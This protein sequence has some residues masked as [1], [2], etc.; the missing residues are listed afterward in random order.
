[1]TVPFQA[2]NVLKKKASESR[3]AV[4]SRQSSSDGDG[5]NDSLDEGSCAKEADPIKLENLKKRMKKYGDITQNAR[6]TDELE[7]L[8]RRFD[9]RVPAV[10]FFLEERVRAKGTQVGRK[11]MNMFTQKF[12]QPPCRRTS[13][14]HSTIAMGSSTSHPALRCLWAAA[15]RR[16]RETGRTKSESHAWWRRM[17]R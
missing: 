3:L 2:S 15:P 14:P 1:M 4:L 8:L 7:E 16:R 13:R 9:N 11:S 6:D 10:I 5:S 17:A 12:M